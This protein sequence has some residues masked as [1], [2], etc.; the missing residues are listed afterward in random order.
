VIELIDIEKELNHLW[1]GIESK[2]KVRAALFNLICFVPDGE[3]LA[4]VERITRFVL[5]KLP[6]RVLFLLFD[7]DSEQEYLR[8][9]AS[10]ER[11]GE[12]DP[13]IL[14]DQIRIAFS[15]EYAERVPFLVTPHLLPDLPISLLWEGDPTDQPKIFPQLEK[16][17]GRILFDPS[18]LPQLPDFA[19]FT[20]NLMQN[21]NSVVRDQKWGC[22]EG[23]RKVIRQISSA[24]EN[25]D[26]L[27]RASS[28]KIHYSVR[29][30]AFEQDPQIQ[31]VY[32]QS[33]LTS[34]LGWTSTQVELIEEQREEEPFGTVV[35]I[36]IESDLGGHFLLE[37]DRKGNF[38]RVKSD[39]PEKCD[40]PYTLFLHHLKR[41]ESFARELLRSGESQHYT[42]TLKFLSAQK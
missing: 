29:K 12:S 15:K 19:R 1:D 24:S 28:V 11:I 6:C 34:Q 8:T 5:G 4:Y 25:L 10:M 26:H 21:T 3:H 7:P 37:H 23:W 38:V 31:A 39:S 32:L 40:L 14:C 16:I 22:C 9:T 30:S 20:L 35:K 41:E 18:S 36:E 42:E 13:P 27:R 33:W 17:A 2:S